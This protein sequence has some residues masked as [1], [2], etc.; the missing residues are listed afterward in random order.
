MS[1]SLAV[2]D[3]RRIA[4]GPTRTMFIGL[5]LKSLASGLTLSLIVLYLSTVRD[6]P[7]SVATALLAWQAVLA[8]GVSPLV[9]TLVDRSGPRP[10][11]LVALLIEAIS[12]FA[13]G[14]VT[15]WQQALLVMSV[16]AVGGAGIWGPTDALLA[17][18]VPSQD[19]SAAFGFQ[20]MLLNLGIGLGGLIGATIIDIDRPSTFELLYALNALGFLAMFVAVLSMGDVGGLPAPDPS[21]AADPDGSGGYGASQGPASQAPADGWATVL[22]DRNL[23]HYAAAALLMLTFGYGSIDSGVAL[24]ITQFVDLDESRIGLVFAANTAVIVLVQLPM[25]SFV[26]GRSRARM[27]AGVGVMWALAWVLFAS[28]LPLPGWL[29]LGAVLLAMSAFA[30]G[31]TLWSPVAPALLNDLAPEHLRGR[32]NAVQSLLWGVSGTLGPLITGLFLSA[33]LGGTWALTLAVGCLL[34]AL[35]AMR[36]RRHLTPGQDGLGDSEES[37]DDDPDPARPE[38]DPDLDPALS[39]EA[40]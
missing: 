12:L 1:V 29:G 23:R 4:H 35:L 16:V 21:V 32:Y 40:R 17:R 30:V 5:F 8:L 6:F 9:G 11:L 15:T 36:L 24:F 7:I 33:D 10:V 28:A 19:R 34:A 39:A 25:I 14:Q 20:F 3:V 13:L 26:R 31:E 37:P 27:L 22:R 38:D 2:A 18:L